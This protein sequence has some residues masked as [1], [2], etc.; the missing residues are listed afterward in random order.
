MRQRSLTGP[1]FV[2]DASMLPVGVPLT[3]TVA[4]ST[5]FVASSS[6][7]PLRIYVDPS[8][9]PS[10]S[11]TSLGL[12]C[13]CHRRKVSS[14]CITAA[15]GESRTSVTPHSRGSKSSQKEEN[16]QEAGDLRSIEAGMQLFLPNLH[17]YANL[18][19]IV[20]V[21]QFFESKDI[22]SLLTFYTGGSG[23]TSDETSLF[24]LISIALQK[25]AEYIQA[26]VNED[27]VLPVSVFVTAESLGSECLS[28]NLLDAQ[29]QDM[30]P[31]VY[32]RSV[33]FISYKTRACEQNASGT[34]RHI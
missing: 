31:T 21:L 34:S 23:N 32:L 9:V 22:R 16:R 29:L 2:A 14:R 13:Q 33:L 26:L 4:V 30:F 25:S 15:A 20:A 17:R 27:I 8:P 10:V 3:L 11:S 6:S 18:T 7:Q 24:A 5:F 1:N 19:F 28:M 12:F